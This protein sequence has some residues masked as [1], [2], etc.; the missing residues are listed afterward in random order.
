MVITWQPPG[1]GNVDRYELTYSPRN[2]SP[3]PPIY[4]YTGELLRT[5]ITGLNPAQTY[6]FIV[7]SE[8]GVDQQNILTRSEP[9]VADRGKGEGIL[10]VDHHLIIKCLMK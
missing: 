10:Q 8:A 7:T 6:I 5:V 2:G 9:V 1:Y 4:V 3:P